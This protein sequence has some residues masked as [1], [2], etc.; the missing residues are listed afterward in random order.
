MK[1]GDYICTIL[2]TVDILLGANLNGRIGKARDDANRESTTKMA[3]VFLNLQK[4]M[5]F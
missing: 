5:A 1:H 4:H 3:K 2:K